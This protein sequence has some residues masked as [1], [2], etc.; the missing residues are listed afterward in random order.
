MLYLK[1]YSANPTISKMTT[2]SFILAMGLLPVV[3]TTPL[4]ARSPQISN[5]VSSGTA[6]VYGICVFETDGIGCQLGNGNVLLCDDGTVCLNY[7]ARFRPRCLQ[8]TR[9]RA[10][11]T[12]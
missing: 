7:I 9:D 8:L 6:V 5:G 3:R 4:E 12:R 10:V 11:C 2:L 1:W